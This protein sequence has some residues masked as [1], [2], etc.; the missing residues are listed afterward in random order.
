MSDNVDIGRQ[1][2]MHLISLGHRNI[3]YVGVCP[4]K[5][6]TQPI[7]GPVLPKP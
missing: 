1:A 2:V 5:S 4:I 3:A 7:A 6:A